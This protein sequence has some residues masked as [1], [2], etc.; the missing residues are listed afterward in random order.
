ML[1]RTPPNLNDQQTPPNLNNQHLWGGERYRPPSVESSAR[2]LM[3]HGRRPQTL[4]ES[5]HGV[6]ASSSDDLFHPHTNT[7]TLSH[8]YTL[9]N[10]PFLPDPHY[11][12]YIQQPNRFSRPL[13]HPLTFS[14]YNNPY[15]TSVRRFG[16]VQSFDP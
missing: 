3:E 6:I 15:F 5:R 14:S 2:N 16:P 13:P 4:P 8:P 7:V 1:L 12:A 10:P 11:D 9:P